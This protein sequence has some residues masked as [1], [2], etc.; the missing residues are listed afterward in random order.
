MKKH[1]SLLL[2]LCVSVTAHAT[3]G[4]AP[5]FMP[6]S[7]GV[8]VA[9]E[10]SGLTNHI[11]I[12]DMEKFYGTLAVTPEF[13]RSFREEDIAQCLFG[14]DINCECS[15]I[16]VL[17]N[18]V[19]NR[20]SRSWLADYFALPTDF[21]S[22]LSFKPRI[23]NYLAD[24]YLYLGL[25]EWVSGMFFFIHGPIVNTSWDLNFCE[26][27]IKEG[28]NDYPIGYFAPTVV[29]RSRLRDSVLAYMQDCRGIDLGN[30]VFIEPLNFAKMSCKTKKETA[31]ADLRFALGWNFFQ[32]EDYHVGA[33]LLAAA[34]TGTR[35]K[36]EFLFE[37][38]VG[39]GNH[40]EF[41]GLLWGHL[42]FWRS[43]CEEKFFS[44]WLQANITHL[45]S[46]RQTRF[47]DLK[48]KPMSRYMLAER[49]TTDVTLLLANVDENTLAGSTVPSN[50]F[51]KVFAPVANLTAQSVDVTVGVQADIVTMLTY[52]SCGFTW[53]VGYNFWARTCENIC[54]NADCPPRLKNENWGL[55]GNAYVFG[56]TNQ[57]F[58]TNP[59]NTPVALS[60]TQS[61]ATIHSG[62]NV[63]LTTPSVIAANQN[64][65]IDN[66]QWAVA[67]PS[68]GLGGALLLNE[69]GGL[70]TGTSKDP[71]I[72]TC[73]DIDYDGGSTKGLSNKIFTHFSYA[74]LD[75]EDW[76]PYIGVGGEI[77]FAQQNND[78]KNQSCN[79]NPCA[80]N[81][82]SGSSCVS[83][84]GCS[85]CDSDCM[86]CGISQWGVWI[87]GGI[88]FN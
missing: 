33:G 5:L 60:A 75:N 29:E 59:I 8:N 17:G 2:S 57:A 23:S 22:S 51:N 13:T 81:N 79:T 45:F 27:I 14:G 62:T 55:K 65:V 37:P 71:I 4:V 36:G 46:S 56:F 64:S 26:N 88:S 54:P 74:W 16:D 24:I 44:G 77:E 49:M 20:G 68:T 12:F 21:E 3:C 19:T 52:T 25:D 15:S 1:I 80:N 85:T 82:C 70:Q 34:P 7:Q 11:A 9:R 6:R 40:W 69:P 41:G 86:R 58:D 42:T 35:P 53:D 50:Q 38:I 84:G 83:S 18:D 66:R 76:T 31:L 63:D 39:N 48:C 78:C 43:E 61:T 72:L 47:F 10:L 28:T 32:D 73:A 87:K 67:G 30:N